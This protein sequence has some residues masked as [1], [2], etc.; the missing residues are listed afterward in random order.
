VIYLISPYSDPDPAVREQRFQVACA[1][2]ARLLLDGHDVYSPVVHGHPLVRYGLSADWSFWERYDREHLERCDEVVVLTLDG[3]RDSIGVQAE[4]RH[5]AV[6]GKPVRYVEPDGETDREAA[7]PATG[8]IERGL[9]CRTCGSGELGV[10]YTRGRRGGVVQ[11]RRKCGSCG[12]RVT[13]WERI[14]PSG[15]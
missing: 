13:T 14:V 1:V 7:R 5:A 4:L 12:R 11:R 3:W 10:V 8:G 15:R 6:L 9:R 2:T